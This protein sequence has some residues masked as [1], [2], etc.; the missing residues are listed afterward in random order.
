MA[1]LAEEY[2]NPVY[3]FCRS[4]TY[5]KEDAEDLF[6]ETFLK[7]LQQPSKVNFIGSVQSF[8]F[9]TALYLWK[10]QKRKYARRS[11]IAPVKPLDET[12]KNS[13]N[14]EE[15]YIQQEEIRTVRQLVESLPDKFKIPVIMYY[16]AELSVSDIAKAMHIPTGTV[17]SRLF[18]ARNLI[19][20]GLVA[21]EYEKR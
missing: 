19:K 9:S 7:V 6:Q 5:S 16:T 20:K 1:A 3:R 17:K 4:L 11:R 18:K 2:K 10:S 21:I 14:V 12:V 15:D 8:L 13:A